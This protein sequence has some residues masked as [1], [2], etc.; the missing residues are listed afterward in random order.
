MNT[1]PHWLFRIGEFFFWCAAGS[2]FGLVVAYF[3]LDG[4]DRQA[5]MQER[6]DLNWAKGQ[7]LKAPAV[8]KRFKGTQECDVVN[9]RDT[10]CALTDKGV[11]KFA[12]FR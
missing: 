3:L 6:Q 5:E 7:L 8:Y 10:V 12:A 2:L 11:L 4:L 9:G 1:L